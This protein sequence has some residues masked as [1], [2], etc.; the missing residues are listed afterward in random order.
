[1]DATR[2]LKIVDKARALKLWEEPAKSFKET[3]RQALRSLEVPKREAVHRSWER[4]DRMLSLASA[5]SN[6]FEM[7]ASPEWSDLIT[8]YESRKH[9]FDRE[10][11]WVFVHF[12]DE[13]LV[14]PSKF[15]EELIQFGNRDPAWFLIAGARYFCTVYSTAM[16]SL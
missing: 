11:G 1:M 3:Q 10:S 14:P 4:L 2:K 9:W 13:N 5:T 7:K 8:D 15:A 16:C 6:P 12:G